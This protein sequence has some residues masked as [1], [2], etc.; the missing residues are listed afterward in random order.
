MDKPYSVRLS[1]EVHDKIQSLVEI[2]GLTSKEFFQEMV[3]KYE[4]EQMKQDTPLLTNDVKEMEMLTQRIYNLFLALGDRVNVSAELQ[5]TDF[6][7]LKREKDDS[8]ELLQ[9]QIEDLKANV[10]EYKEQV[11]LLI[12][13]KENFQKENVAHEKSYED[14]IKQLEDTNSKNDDIIFS[15]KDKIKDLES[16]M[17]QFESHDKKLENLSDAL[18][19]SKEKIKNLEKTNSDLVSNKKT[20]ENQYQ[21][22]AEIQRKG[23]DL[24]KRS[25]IESTTRILDEMRRKFDKERIGLQDRVN[26]LLQG[27]SSSIE[28]KSRI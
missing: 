10:L 15:Y 2:S 5:K 9:N 7:N 3:A 23:F 14:K 4:I 21:S 17:K 16:R 27:K 22:D 25:V 12:A 8:I 19:E 20:L 28:I 13:D 1:P 18:Q 11:G 24:E 6:E 26:K